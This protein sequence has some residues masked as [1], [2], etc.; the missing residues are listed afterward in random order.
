M[1]NTTSLALLVLGAALAR[2]ASLSEEA[3]AYDALFARDQA[4]YVKLVCS[5]KTEA[6]GPVPPCVE[7]AVIESACTPNGNTS[8]ALEAH[9]Q[10]MCKGSYFSD[11]I[12]CQN[13][14]LAH[15]ARSPRDIAY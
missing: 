9:A 3:R 11:W 6:G 15:G 10:C 7:I 8:L 2:A 4:D 14:L 12:G 5:P 13:C 1:L